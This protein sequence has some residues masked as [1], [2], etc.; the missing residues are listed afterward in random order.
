MLDYHPAKRLVMADLI[1][2]PWMQGEFPTD[3]EVAEEFTR[4]KQEVK[5]AQDEERAAKD[6]EKQAMKQIEQARPTRKVVLV[7][8]KVYLS[9]GELTEEEKKM[10]ENNEVVQLETKP[11]DP[12]VDSNTTV[13]TDQAVE[14]IFPVLLETL[15]ETGTPF[16]ISE[17]TW[18]L[19]FTK[20]RTYEIEKG[21]KPYIEQAT[22]L[23]ELMD[24]GD[25]G[26]CV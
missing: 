25:Q 11:Y 3:E 2:H 20:S 26:I 22:I 17:K 14:N 4:R 13:F 1:G 15:E 18:K 6:A 21:Q 5:Q 19:T 10:K 7:N 16:N 12:L 24:A 8:G 23:V 9:T